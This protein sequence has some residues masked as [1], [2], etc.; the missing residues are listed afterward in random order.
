MGNPQ[1]ALV[2]PFSAPFFFF[3]FF[4]FED[5]SQRETLTGNRGSVQAL[6]EASSQMSAI[7][8]TSEEENLEDE[9]GDHQPHGEETPRAERMENSDCSQVTWLTPLLLLY[10]FCS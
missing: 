3:F 5:L 2:Q 9:D 1:M 6:L 8:S 10:C 4:P 7:L